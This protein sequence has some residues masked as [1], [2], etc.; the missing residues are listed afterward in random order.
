M[1]QSSTH[2][3]DTP[4]TT[5]KP[6]SAINASVRWAH[7]EAGLDPRKLQFLWVNP[8]ALTPLRVSP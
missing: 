6:N 7:L 2:S 4:Y 1:I 5:I 3:I 8:D